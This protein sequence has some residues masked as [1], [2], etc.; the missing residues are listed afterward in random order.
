MIE[1][2]VKLF[3]SS[4]ITGQN[5]LKCLSLANFCG[6]GLAIWLIHQWQRK[7]IYNIFG[8]RFEKRFV[9]NHLL[10]DKIR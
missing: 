4:Q 3:S 6:N 5:T 9:L 10:G 1:K 7:K 8:Q 2:A